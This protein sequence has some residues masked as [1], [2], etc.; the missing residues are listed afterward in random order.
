MKSGPPE[1]DG[2]EP[3]LDNVL[4]GALRVGRRHRYWW[5]PRGMVPYEW[6]LQRVATAIQGPLTA[7]GLV[8]ALPVDRARRVL[9]VPSADRDEINS[10]EV[11]IE[12]LGEQLRVMLVGEDW[13]SVDVLDGLGLDGRGAV[14][15]RS[16]GTFTVT[17]GRW[18]RVA[19]GSRAGTLVRVQEGEPRVVPGLVSVA[20][21]G[22]G[23][24][25]WMAGQER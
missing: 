12:D 24:L 6:R 5:V 18:G 9:L 4:E 7:E 22:R 13:P 8:A 14:V 15:E 23:V 25:R 17:L 21:A 11:P 2:D 20:A 19:A 16:G 3:D 1:S 10:V